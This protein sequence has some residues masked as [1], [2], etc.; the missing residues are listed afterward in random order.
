M[1]SAIFLI[2]LILGVISLITVSA[3]KLRNNKNY[4]DFETDYDNEFLEEASED[5]EENL[6]EKCTR[7]VPK[8]SA[9]PKCT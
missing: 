7:T 5:T 4:E 3:T 1:K 8:T 6:A 9:Y 2:I